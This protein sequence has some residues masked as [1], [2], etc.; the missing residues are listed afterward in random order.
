LDI[1]SPLAH[2]CQTETFRASFIDDAAGDKQS[3]MSGARG[4]RS[5]RSIHDQ[6]HRVKLL[7]IMRPREGVDVAREVAD[8]ARAELRALWNL[9]REGLVREMYSP[10]G[11][12]AVLVLEAGSI[13]EAER[14]LSELPLLAQRIMSLELIELRPFGAIEMLF[15]GTDGR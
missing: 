6:G 11:P 8:H 3:E 14:A 2:A 5:K 4:A 10:G 7:A 15:D 1:A 9:Y 12:G 13:T